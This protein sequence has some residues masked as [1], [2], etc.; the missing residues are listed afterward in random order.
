[1]SRPRLAA[2]L[3]LL[4][5]VGCADGG[6]RG[7]GISSFAG[8]VVAVERGAP[9]AA[10]GALGGIVV[11]IEGTGLR[12][13]TDGGGRFA[14]R[15]AFAGETAVRFERPEDGLA[16]RFSVNAPAGGTTT[17]R[18]VT[19]HAG[20]GEASPAA[21]YMAFEGRVVGVDCAADRL[22][23]ASVGDPDEAGDD[24]YVLVLTDSSVRD[25]A[26]HPLTCDAFAVGDRMRIAGAYA[27]DGTIG[28]A[29]VT[30]H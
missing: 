6:Q 5:C 9:A 26:G 21:V 14:L 15:G 28:H 22:V 12:T 19:L 1:M 13:E 2:M 7:T 8:N 29:D 17:L 18:D 27:Q 25:D 20:S 11:T 24:P 4:V 23:C 10:S 30:R 3:G 16:A